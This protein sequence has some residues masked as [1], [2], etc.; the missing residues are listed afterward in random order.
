MAYRAGAHV[1]YFFPCCC[2]ETHTVLNDED[3]G[4]FGSRLAELPP[5]IIVHTAAG[6]WHVPRVYVVFHGLRANDVP[7]LAS[8]YNWPRGDASERG[9]SWRG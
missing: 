3:H 6:S 7:S 9:Y 8:V 2:G 4:A 1:D 5:D